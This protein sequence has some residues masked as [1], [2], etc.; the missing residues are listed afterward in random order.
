MFCED[1]AVSLQGIHCLVF[2]LL[3]TSKNHRLGLFREKKTKNIRAAQ[4]LIQL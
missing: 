1:P 4:Y 3:K 2:D